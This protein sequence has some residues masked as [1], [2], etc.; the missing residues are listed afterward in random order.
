MDKIREKERISSPKDYN[1]GA[2]FPWMSIQISMESQ[3]SLY[4]NSSK[5]DRYMT[6]LRHLLINVDDTKDP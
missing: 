4:I 1:L 2:S 5:V 3:F 6:L